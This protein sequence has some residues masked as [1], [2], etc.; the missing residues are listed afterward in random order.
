MVLITKFTTIRHG[1]YSNMHIFTMK[2]F[3]VSNIM[4]KSK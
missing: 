2:N 4:N 3:I 1:H